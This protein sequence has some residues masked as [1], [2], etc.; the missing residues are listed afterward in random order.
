MTIMHQQ[1][2]ALTLN[3]ITK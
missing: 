3:T 1:C 2:V